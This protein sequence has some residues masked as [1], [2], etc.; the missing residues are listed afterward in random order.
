MVNFVWYSLGGDS[1]A[2]SVFQLFQMGEVSFA[3][4]NLGYFACVEI[5][6]LVEIAL[7]KYKIES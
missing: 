7:I 4:S 3:N 6:F 2:E 5:S 1:L